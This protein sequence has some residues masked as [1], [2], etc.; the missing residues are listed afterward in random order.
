MGNWNVALKRCVLAL[1]AAAVALTFAQTGHTQAP[2][3]VLRGLDPLDVLNSGVRHNVWVVLDHS[4]SMDN[5][6]IDPVTG[7]NLGTKMEVATSVLT[8]VMTEFV[9]AS[10][11]PL[12]NCLRGF[13][14]VHWS[15]RR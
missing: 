1:V 5:N 7:D 10:G 12:V 13:R 6:V 14:D 15:I 9:D 2:C 4:G 3:T 8:E 11:R